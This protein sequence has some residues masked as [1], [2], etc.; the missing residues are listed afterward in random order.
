MKLADA[1]RGRRSARAYTEE[2]VPFNIVSEIVNLSAHAPSACNRR[3]WRSILIQDPVDLDWLYRCGGSEVFR[4]AAQVLLVCYE[5]GTENREWQDSIQSAAAF[6]AYFQLVAH[7]RGIGSCWLCHLPPKR[8]VAARFAIPA[9][10][11]P[12]AALSFGYYR[13]GVCSVRPD[14]PE[15]KLLALDRWAFEEGAGLSSATSGLRRL[16]RRIYYALPFRSVL[17]GFAGR[18]EKRFDE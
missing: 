18:F 9:A 6:I 7:D 15:A 12:V 4:T 16:C 10:Y 8:E 2:R 3:G 14:N 17:R 13:D 5:S 1:I 11:E